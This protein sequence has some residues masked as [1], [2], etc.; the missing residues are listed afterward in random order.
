MCSND[1]KAKE[2]ELKEKFLELIFERPLMT[3]NYVIYL[4][5]IKLSKTDY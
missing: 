4:E 1:L 2:K 3:C 5:T